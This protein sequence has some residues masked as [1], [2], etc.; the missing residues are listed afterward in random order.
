MNLDAYLMSLKDKF[1]GAGFSLA[2]EKPLAYGCQLVVS[3]G[4]NKVSVNVY[5]GKKGISVVV[6]GAS[7]SELKQAVQAVVDGGTVV[8]GASIPGRPAGFEHVEDFDDC[9]IGTDESGKG[10]FFGPLVAAAV[11]VDNVIAD[12]LA[13]IGVKDSKLLSD[14]KAR[15][16]AARIREICVDGYV[17]LEITPPRYNALYK[18]LKS[19]GKNLNHLLAWAHARALE[20]LLGKAACR[21]AIADK[22][23]DE[24]FIQ[25]R[26]M[27][28]GRKV[29]L[30]QTPKA[31]RNIAV[32]AASILARDRFLARMDDLSNK[33]GIVFPK[34][35]SQQVIEVGKQF[36]SKFGRDRLADVAK[37]HF[38]TAEELG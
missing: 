24:K 8:C 37:I 18:Q 14:V 38:K 19:E 25:S 2:G 35:A 1:V 11:R 17:E 21:F 10:D 12:Q 3:D 7:G 32:A 33:L 23:A 29:V 4:T 22:F 5:S 28:N 15:A 36:V 6:G 13:G 31:E 26:L 9:W 16:I 27:A 20:D 34:G 30:V